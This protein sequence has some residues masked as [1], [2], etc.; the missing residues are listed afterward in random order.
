MSAAVESADD[1][2][3]RTEPLA[4]DDLCSEEVVRALWQRADEIVGVRQTLFGITT[5]VHRTVE[6]RQN[7]F[8]GDIAAALD[9][10]GLV[11]VPDRRKSAAMVER[12]R[13]L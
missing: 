10:F 8:T 2:L 5:V 9:W 3:S 12:L 11:D 1:A 6:T 13:R 7:I 4:R